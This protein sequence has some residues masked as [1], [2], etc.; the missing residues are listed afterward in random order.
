MHVISLRSQ[1]QGKYFDFKISMRWHNLGLVREFL[2][3]DSLVGKLELLL[4]K[5]TNTKYIAGYV[6]YSNLYRLV[7]MLKIIYNVHH[8]T[9]HIKYFLYYTSPM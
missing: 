8:N 2:E 1:D 4:E 9:F 5:K 7:G 3:S 6:I